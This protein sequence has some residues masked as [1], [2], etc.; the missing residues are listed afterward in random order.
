VRFDHESVVRLCAAGYDVVSNWQFNG[1]S[2]QVDNFLVSLHGYQRYERGR[3][4][5]FNLVFLEYASFDWSH[6]T[7]PQILTMIQDIEDE[8]NVPVGGSP[9]GVGLRYLQK[10]NEKHPQWLA[11]PA[12]DL[13]IIPFNQ[14]AR[15]LI[16]S[17]RPTTEELSRRFLYKFDKNSAYP[18]AAVD[19]RFGVGNPVHTDGRGFDHMLPGIWKVDVDFSPE[20]DAL[21]P[22]PLWGDFS[23]IATP[24]VR[25]LIKIGCGIHI[26]EAWVF[27]KHEYVFRKWGANLW[28]YSQYYERGTPERAAYKQIMNEPLGLVRSKMFGTDS[29][30][31]RPDWNSTIVAATRADVL[32]KTY[33]YGM[34]GYYPIMVQLDAIYYLSDERLPNLALPGILDHAGSLGG[35]KMDFCLE[36]T[37]E[38]RTA[39]STLSGSK[40]LHALNALAEKAGY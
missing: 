13:S 27:P 8:L 23:W 12:L 31:Y 2:A 19:E 4:P 26:S 32:R 34:L 20:L 17:R 5:R 36:M 18:R 33:K 35:Y 25:F 9:A 39:L 10:I 29:F 7:P 16:W 30:K 1:A 37:D 14:A 22:F 21:L 24:M 3:S 40:R 15:P 38:A 11:K 28:E 6:L